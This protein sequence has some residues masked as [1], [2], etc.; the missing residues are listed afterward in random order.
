MINGLRNLVKTSKKATF[1]SCEARLACGANLAKKLIEVQGEP[2]ALELGRVE[3]VLKPAKRGVMTLFNRHPLAKLQSELE[4]L[5][6]EKIL[7]HVG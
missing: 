3:E 7:E 4:S 5:T 6:T 1:V 2:S